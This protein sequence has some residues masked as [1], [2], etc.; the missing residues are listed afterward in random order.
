MTRLLIVAVAVLAAFAGGV[1]VGWRAGH[2]GASDRAAEQAQAQ[3]RDLVADIER[4]VTAR[5]AQLQAQ[6]VA[7]TAL[8]ATQR[9]I[10]S[11]ADMVREDIRHAV[12]VVPLPADDPV[13]S[14]EFVRLYNAAARAGTGA[15]ATRD[16]ARRVHADGP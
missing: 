14:P 13:G 4:Q 16:P 15:A 7:S 9:A 11:R 8:L 3:T 1:G 6:L 12:F 2:A 10:A 5:Q